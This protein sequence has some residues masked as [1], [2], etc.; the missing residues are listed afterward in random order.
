MKSLWSHR[1]EAGPQW[2][3]GKSLRKTTG[4]AATKSEKK[5]AC[6]TRMGVMCDVTGKGSKAPAAS[7]SKSPGGEKRKK[8]Q[9]PSSASNEK[10]KARAS[11]NKR[12]T[13]H[14]Q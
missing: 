1:H 7:K 3:L 6:N 10:L 11:Y 8:E 9:A 13:T 14:S 5:L 4:N 12:P 2:R